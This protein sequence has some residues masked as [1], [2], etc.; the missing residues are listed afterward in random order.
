MATILSQL[1]DKASAFPEGWRLGHSQSPSVFSF[2]HLASSPVIL[3]IIDLLYRPTLSKH[4]VKIEVEDCPSLIQS[5]ECWL[6]TFCVLGMRGDQN[7]LMRSSS[8]KCISRKEAY[9]DV[10][11]Q[12]K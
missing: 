2:P 7:G 8:R 6:S 5:S 4:L 12:R 3:S 1:R 11:G 10:T 9:V